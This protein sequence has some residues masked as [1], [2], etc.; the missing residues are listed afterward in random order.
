MRARNAFLVATGLVTSLAACG[1]PIRTGNSAPPSVPAPGALTFAWNQERD[2]VLGD[3]RLDNN[4][5][6]EDRLH[7][8]VEWELSLRGIRRVDSNPDLMVHHHLSLED[9]ED[10][11]ETI[12]EAGYTTTEAYSYEGGTVVVHLVSTRTGENF[13]LAWGQ[14]NIEPALAGPESMRTWVYDLVRKMFER[15]PVPARGGED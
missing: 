5:F 2:R 15:W 6:F 3:P 10:M 9:H 13:W 4:R 14:A 1:V 7:E 12:D 11:V 8:A